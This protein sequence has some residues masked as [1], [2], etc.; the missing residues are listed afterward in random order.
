MKTN[1]V[2]T[3]SQKLKNPLLF[4]GL[5]VLCI[6]VIQIALYVIVDSV[7]WA[8]MTLSQ[9]IFASIVNPIALWISALV[10]IVMYLI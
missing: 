3:A 10:A 9:L 5:V 7:G 1:E 2:A 6:A 8:E 4:A